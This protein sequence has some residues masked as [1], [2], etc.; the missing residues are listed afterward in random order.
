MNERQHSAALTVTRLDAYDNTEIF[1]DAPDP[2]GVAGWGLVWRLK[3]QHFGIRVDGRLVAHAGLVVLPLS[4]GESRMD[5]V[6]LGGVGVAS[7]QRGRGLARLVVNGAL[8]Y[9]QVLGPEFAILFCRPD[10]AGLYTRLGWRTLDGDV[11]VEQPAGVAVMP[12][13]TMWLPLRQGS[14]WPEGAVRLHSRPM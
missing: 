12:L 10:V 14:R 5:V 6:G 1:G 13:R 3:D 11:E 9:A 8:E 7:D 4:V 2:F